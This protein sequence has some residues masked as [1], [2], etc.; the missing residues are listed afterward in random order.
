MVSMNETTS[1]SC[2]ISILYP[3]TPG[4]SLIPGLALSPGPLD[5]PAFIMEDREKAGLRTRL[6]QVISSILTLQCPIVPSLACQ[7]YEGGIVAE[8]DGQVPRLRPRGAGP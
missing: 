7:P 3:T 4:V 2:T 6:A 8:R 1:Y 5:L